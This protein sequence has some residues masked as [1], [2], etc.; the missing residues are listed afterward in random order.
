MPQS[1]SDYHLLRWHSPFPIFLLVI[2]IAIMRS[3]K[4]RSAPFKF[5]SIRRHLVTICCIYIFFLI[6]FFPRFVPLDSQFDC[7]I[8]GER[9]KC[10]HR[11]STHP[12]CEVKIEE[13]V[14][15]MM[16]NELG[17]EPIWLFRRD[18]LNNTIY[19]SIRWQ[20]KIDEKR[21]YF[22]LKIAMQ[23]RQT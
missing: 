16:R 20:W 23:T 12:P 10:R 13:D 15:V 3:L 2:W 9:I 1:N 4:M 5:I 18:E 22:I 21:N 8:S 7:C 14:V 19:R 11:A 6:S 17:L